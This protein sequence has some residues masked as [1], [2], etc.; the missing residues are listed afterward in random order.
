MHRCATPRRR[1]NLRRPAGT[2]PP[3]TPDPPTLA[4]LLAP[5]TAMLTD[6]MAQSSMRWSFENSMTS[7]D[8][9]GSQTNGANWGHCVPVYALGAMAGIT[10]TFG[11]QTPAAKLLA[12]LLYWTEPAQDRMPVGD[13]GYKGQYEVMF[14]SAVAIAKLTPAVWNDPSLTT[15]RKARLD[16]AMQGCLAGS[17]WCMSD[18]NL[19]IGSFSTERTI[20]GF[21]TGRDANPNFSSPPKLIIQIAAGYLGRSAAAT[22][23]STFDRDAFSAA[24]TAAGGLG[25]MALLFSQNWTTSL[26]DAVYGK[27]SGARTGPTKAQLETA[28]RGYSYQSW[29]VNEADAAAV[30]AEQLEY[31]FQKTIRPGVIGWGGSPYG[32]IG[33]STNGQLRAVIDDTS[34]WA[35]VPNNGLIGA[36][37]ELDTINGNYTPNLRS[38]MSYVARGVG[39]VFAGMVALAAQGLHVGRTAALAE[40]LTRARRGVTHL[41]Y[42]TRYGYRS[43]A[44][45]GWNGS[46]WISNNETWTAAWAAAGDYEVPCRWGLGDCLVSAL[47]GTRSDTSTLFP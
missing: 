18:N 27:S 44:K 41:R 30:M 7:D 36:P 13:S 5:T 8:T 16:L 6:A 24:C 46:S 25:K 40:G 23:L 17:A 1:G 43:Y 4:E 11:G 33:A 26:V 32:I 9:G 29:E 14:V 2:L 45:G 47:S 21:Q 3:V 38:S 19:W 37:F 20:M 15:E 39:A 35:G 22:F 12:Q 34:A 31:N 10:T 28:V 42:V